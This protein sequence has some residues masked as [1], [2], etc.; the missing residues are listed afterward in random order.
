MIVLASASPR[1]RDLLEQAGIAFRVIPAQIEEWS[2]DRGEAAAV[3]EHNARAKAEAVAAGE[4]AAVVL[5]ADTVV[6][7]GDRLLGKPLDAAAARSTLRTLSGTTHGVYT[8]VAVCY[9]NQTVS[10]VVRTD[11]TMRRLTETEIDEYVASG[12][13]FGKAGAYAVQG[14]AESF[15]KCLDGPYDNVV[16]LPVAT[17]RALVA[18]AGAAL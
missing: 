18:E 13:A 11:V 6:A 12:E 8:G 16:G 2:P 1:R 14:A 4:P 17:V 5:G 15:V 10:R 3:A 7:K 9:R